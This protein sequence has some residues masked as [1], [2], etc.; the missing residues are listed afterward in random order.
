MVQRRGSLGSKHKKR[1]ASGGENS[2]RTIVDILEKSGIPKSPVPRKVKVQVE[3]SQSSQKSTFSQEVAHATEESVLSIDMG[4]KA[5]SN[6]VPKAS[7]EFCIYYARIMKICQ[8]ILYTPK[9]ISE[10]DVKIPERPAG[11]L[12]GS[13]RIQGNTNSASKIDTMKEVIVCVCHEISQGIQLKIR[14]IEESKQ[15]HHLG[16]LASRLDRIQ[17]I[18]LEATTEKSNRA[19][20][21]PEK[22]RDTDLKS[23]QRINFEPLIQSLLLTINATSIATSAEELFFY[24]RVARSIKKLYS[25]K[26][27]DKSEVSEYLIKRPST[28]QETKVDEIKLKNL[29]S[30]TQQAFKDVIEKI[31]EFKLNLEQATTLSEA[32]FV[33]KTVKNIARIHDDSIAT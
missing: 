15:S 29:Q 10:I 5:L 23:F 24:A 20:R 26:D 27:S 6:L 17:Q 32:V 25:E 19:T 4:L 2:G 31:K 21:A 13:Q 33:A 1:T 18:L 9:S 8:Q 7:M 12:A 22:S 14:E 30:A 16:V 11:I 3:N 28:K